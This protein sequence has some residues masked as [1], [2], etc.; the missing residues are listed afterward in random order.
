MLGVIGF[1]VLL[2][3][4]CIYFVYYSFCVGC[5]LVLS[6]VDFRFGLV[7]DFILIGVDWFFEI[8]FSF[9]CCFLFIRY[10]ILVLEIVFI[11]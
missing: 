6:D 11:Y 5:N 7:V 3:Y 2:K 1:I 4:F 9:C 10:C 8:L